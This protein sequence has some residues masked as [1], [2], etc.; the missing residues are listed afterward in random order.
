[1]IGPERFARRTARSVRPLGCEIEWC[2]PALLAHALAA[3]SSEVIVARSGAWL[4]RA[5]NLP[6]HPAGGEWLAV[7][8]RIGDASWRRALAGCGG[9]FSRL[10]WW[11]RMPPAPPV[12]LLSR[13][14]ARAAAPFFANGVADAWH[15]LLRAGIRVVHLPE[16]DAHLTGQLR[17]LQLVTTIQIGGAERVTL[18]LAAELPSH[19]V[20]SCVATLGAPAR[21]TF[22][23]P[24]GLVDLS[25]VRNSPEARAE[26]VL[27]IARE[28][29]ADL[30]HA[31]LIRGSEAAA[32][33]AAG[34]PLVLTAHNLPP[35]WP[36]GFDELRPADSALLI[37]CSRAVE[38]ELR[39][40]VPAIPARTVWNGIAPRPA[41][42]AGRR[43]D[44][45]VLILAN[46]RAQ[47]RLDLVPAIAHALAALLAPRPVRFILAGA[48]AAASEDAAAAIDALDAAIVRHG[49]SDLIVRR[50]LVTDTAALFAD[51]DVLLSVSA[52]EG[53]S[54]AHL[55]ALAAG[56]PV[57]ATDAGGTREIA[58]QSGAVT[59]LPLDVTAENCA[60]ALAEAA[61]RRG[62]IPV[63]LPKSFTRHAMVRRAAW[64]YPRALAR[65]TRNAR[66][67]GL[68]LVTNNFSTG[69][70]QSSARR[71]LLALHGEGLRVRAAVVQ[72]HPEHPT[73]GRRTLGAAGVPVLAVPPA[74]ERAVEDAALPL[75]EAIE[76][77]PPRV[78]VF[79]N[80]IA[81]WKVN[82][83]DALLDAR[84]F[85]VSPGE[86]FFSSLDRFFERVPAGLPYQT[87]RDY[88]SL[89][90]G[91]VVKYRAEAARAADRLG[92]AVTVIPNGVPQCTGSPARLAAQAPSGG[93][94]VIGTAARLS[95]DKRLGGWRRRICRHS[96]SGSQAVWSVISRNTG[97]SC[98]SRRS[99][100]RWSS[101]VKSPTWPSS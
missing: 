85:D 27:R 64:L 75:I 44:L 38:L 47:K 82:L 42:V 62:E 78:V 61:A 13:D 7:G 14:C 6:V 26:A 93:K 77:D 96:C 89:L 59:L 54:L 19:G 76:R 18:D 10:R 46:P 69:G 33:S 49:V 55:E 40:A 58:A 8:A 32:I 34:L 63:R 4:A 91:V 31:H 66:P 92:C 65:V 81:S 48:D 37:G 39:R 72:E 80:L 98:G 16:L 24:P 41:A 1:V 15:A 35:G 73:P 70:A 51:A 86:M 95:P 100:C 83:A 43:K 68:W 17:V 52:Y 28:F 57:V 99:D 36:P 97:P 12:M 88:G 50:G 22:P 23:A 21:A 67:E 56:L 45:R 3:A 79:W 84:L 29:G 5:A 90:A 101:W 11:Q 71:L 20:A 53:L 74:G 87:P 2:E 94:L 60:E 30:V 9:D 25:G